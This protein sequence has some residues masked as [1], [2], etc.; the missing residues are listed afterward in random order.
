RPI[1][2]P[3]VIRLEERLPLGDAL[4][5][6]LLAASWLAASLGSIPE[7]ETP[8]VSK[9]DSSAGLSLAIQSADSRWGGGLKG[10]GAVGAIEVASAPSRPVSSGLADVMD[11]I[12]RATAG[13]RGS[14]LPERPVSLVEMSAAA[15][16]TE[17]TSLTAYF[18][19]P[20]R[21]DNVGLLQALASV[22]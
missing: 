6:P 3:R 22:R 4:V 18:G 20:G 10:N 1:Y 16:G 9:R 17:T 15:T 11:L 14:S 8:P 12:T 7:G 2:R 19:R 13:L 5:G 21:A